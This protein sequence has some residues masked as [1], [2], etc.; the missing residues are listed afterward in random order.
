VG[1]SAFGDVA[2]LAKM[3]VQVLRRRILGRAGWE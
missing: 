3:I 1:G 2:A